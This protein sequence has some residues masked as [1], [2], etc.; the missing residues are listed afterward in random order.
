MKNTKFSERIKELRE[1]HGYSM[2]KL[3][4]L[5][6]SHYSAKMN[7]S[8]LSRYE[9]GLQDPVYTVVV[10][11]AN[12]FNVSVDYMSGNDT[13]FLSGEQIKNLRKKLG[14][15][16]EDLGSKLGIN[17]STVY[18]YENGDIKKLPADIMIT[19]TN[20]LDTST[21]VHT[22]VK[23]LD[24]ELPNRIKT[25]RKKRR[26]TLEYVG[27]ACGVGKSTVRKWEN[28]MIAN[29]HRDKL[30][31]LAEVLGVTPAYLTGYEDE[32]GNPVTTMQLS[33]EER[34]L[35]LAFRSASA[36]QKEIARLAL[37]ELQK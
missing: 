30:I 29:M 14:I 11:F 34:T 5:Y 12:F 15:T 16:A 35:I 32:N 10:N 33:P 21:L 8:T 1:T 7:K 9:N 23:N 19:L 36:H 3:V 22:K 6:N 18:R 37:I 27:N 20:Y 31:K 13:V 24:S 25:L 26:Y 17:R 4:E 28:G 2:D